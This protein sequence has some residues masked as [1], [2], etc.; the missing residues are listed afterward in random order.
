MQKLLQKHAVEYYLKALT[1]SL[2][3]PVVARVERLA[4]L[5]LHILQYLYLYAKCDEFTTY[6]GIVCI[7][8]IIS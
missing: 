7:I 8:H 1:S 5:T 6:F 2:Q 4:T 3:A